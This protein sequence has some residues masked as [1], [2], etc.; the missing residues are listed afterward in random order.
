MQMDS[1]YSFQ[2][3]SH[4]FAGAGGIPGSPD[5]RLADLIASLSEPLP[6]PVSQ[7]AFQDYRAAA[8]ARGGG[9]NGNVNIHRRMMSV[10]G[11]MAPGSGEDEEE[12]PQ[13]QEQKQQHVG[14]VESSRGFRHMMRER[15]RREKLSQSYA[16]LY[17]MVSSR[18]KQDKNS[19]VQSAASYIHELKVARDQLRRRSEDLK[20]KI[21]GHDAQQPCVKVQFE[22]DEPS[23]S[24]DSMIGALRSLKG[25][26]VKTR[27]IRSTLAGDR[28]TTEINV[29]TT[30]AASE[31]ERAVE[32]ALQEVERKQLPADSD[33]TF[34]GSRSSNWP[35][36]H[37]QNVF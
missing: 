11:R 10:L 32:E 22:V 37:V 31:V 26:N 17:A 36:S 9:R 16:D 21:L 5:L 23:S 33:N 20:A 14:A 30:I 19:I 4:F 1:Y 34:P 13:Q 27:G 8:G 7:S 6:A 35:Q 3:D 25:M 18:S 15:Q 2:D 12:L 24:I 29:E 28:L